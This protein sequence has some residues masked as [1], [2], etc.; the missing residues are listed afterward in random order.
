MAMDGNRA[1]LPMILPSDSA[2]EYEQLVHT[3]E[4][5]ARQDEGN[6]WMRGK[7]RQKRTR[8]S[9]CWLWLLVLL[10]NTGYTRAFD[11]A[12]ILL[13][14]R[15]TSVQAVAYAELE[16]AVL[17]FMERED[18]S[19]AEG[20][21]A[22]DLRK[23]SLSYSGEEVLKA[24]TLSWTQVLP[25]LPPPEFCGCINVLDLAEGSMREYLEHPERV[26]WRAS[27][28]SGRGR[29]QGGAS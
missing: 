22:G 25:A 3:S 13:P 10:L 18:G 20:D 26:L 21:W 9:R 17:H 27:R 7:R 11:G 15:V 16:H 2:E 24:Q 4:E 5:L 12:P 28:A 29:S 1:L 19:L 8:G 14:G 23:A 6:P